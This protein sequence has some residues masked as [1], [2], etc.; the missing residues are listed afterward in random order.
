MKRLILILMLVM[1]FLR[2]SAQEGLSIAPYFRQDFTK[3]GSVSSV[4]LSG[5]SASKFGLDLY[6]S[7][8]VTDNS[9]VN[10]I[11]KAVKTDGAKAYDKQTA[12]RKGRL[13]FGFYALKGKDSNRFIVFLNSGTDADPKAMLIYMVGDVTVEE[14]KKMMQKF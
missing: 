4:T 10:S 11:E 2:A 5:N 7:V 8:T 14:V 3:S 1:G 12:Y 9:L 6:R 13:H